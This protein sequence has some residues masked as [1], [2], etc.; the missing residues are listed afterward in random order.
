MAWKLSNAQERVRIPKTQR[1]RA[2]LR[3]NLEQDHRETVFLSH[4]HKQSSKHQIA[5]RLLLEKV[6][7]LRGTPLSG[8]STESLKAESGTVTLMEKKKKNL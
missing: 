1:H 3:M 4:H 5:S 8:K 7:D 6:H 2:C